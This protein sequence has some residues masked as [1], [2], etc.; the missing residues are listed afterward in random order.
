MKLRQK[1]KYFGILLMILGI[2]LLIYGLTANRNSFGNRYGTVLT[3]KNDVIYYANHNIYQYNVDKD[4]KMIASDVSIYFR[5][6]GDKLYYIHNNKVICKNLITA[7][8]EFVFEVKS[9]KL[10]EINIYIY[11]DKLIVESQYDTLQYNY[12]NKDSSIRQL[13]LLKT[14]RYM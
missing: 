7:K 9:F 5:L 14:I 3:Y 6:S 2:F 1:T 12:L 8:E 11:D 4:V 13:P 10:R